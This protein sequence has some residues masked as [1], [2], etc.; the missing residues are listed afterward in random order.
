MDGQMDGLNELYECMEEWRDSCT[1][2]WM[3][4]Q[5]DTCRLKDG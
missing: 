3:D 4:E 2:R 5:K 1:C